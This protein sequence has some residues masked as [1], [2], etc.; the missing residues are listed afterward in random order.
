MLAAWQWH[1][2]EEKILIQS[3]MDVVLQNP[4][5][6]VKSFSLIK[7]ERFMSVGLLGSYISDQSFLLDNIV[8][9]G[10]AGYLVVTPFRLSAS[11][12]IILVDRGWIAALQF[13]E[14]LPEIITPNEEI[15]LEGW[16]Q[17][18]RS[19]PSFLVEMENP[20]IYQPG[21]W[22]H[23]DEDYLTEK[24]SE[25]VVGWVVH[26]EATQ[27]HGFLRE[28]PAFDAKVGMHYGYFIHWLVF[29]LFSVAAYL[30]L[31][32]KRRE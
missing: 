2:A 6:Q 23:L 14:Q 1:R 24:L 25:P 17:R 9:N 18:P 12:E 31:I 22:Q 16:L 8:R 29:A 4:V 11:R 10:K 27:P 7:P 20:E 30:S 19:K 15:Q 26:L 5:Q 3:R 28:S 32:I 21:V 13:R